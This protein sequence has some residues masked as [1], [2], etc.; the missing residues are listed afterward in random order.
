MGC[1]DFAA[2]IIWLL[3]RPEE[4]KKMGELGRRRIEGQL[5]WEYSVPPLLAAYRKALEGAHHGV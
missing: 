3:D 5:A 4:R 1:A 2:K